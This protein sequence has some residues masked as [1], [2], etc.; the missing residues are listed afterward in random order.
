MVDGADLALEVV[1]VD[2]LGD[3]FFTDGHAQSRLA[4]AVLNRRYNEALA[5]QLAPRLQNLEK[6]PRLDSVRFDGR[7]RSVIGSGSSFSLKRSILL[8]PS[9]AW[10]E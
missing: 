2:C 8:C 4:I 1:A 9:L 6:L 3:N 5:T 7:T 10:L